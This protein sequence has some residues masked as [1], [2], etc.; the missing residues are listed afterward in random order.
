VRD[1]ATHRILAVYKIGDPPPAIGP[2]A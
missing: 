2:A 1:T